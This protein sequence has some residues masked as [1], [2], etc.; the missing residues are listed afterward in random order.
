[1]RRGC[2]QRKTQGG[3][4]KQEEPL[5]LTSW[6]RQQTHQG[7]GGETQGGDLGTLGLQ[8]QGTLG[9][10]PRDPGNGEELG[11]ADGGGVGGRWS[12][13]RHYQVAVL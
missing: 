4:N 6:W 2:Y 11:D 5:R 9:G 12:L 13:V 3:L 8:G 7:E 1:M 10:G